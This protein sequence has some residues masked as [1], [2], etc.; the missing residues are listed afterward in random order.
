MVRNIPCLLTS[1]EHNSGTDRCAEVLN[2]SEGDYSHVVNIQ[3]DEPMLD[4]ESLDRAI[5]SFTSDSLAQIGSLYHELNI[6]GSEDP[7]KV[8]VVM[9]K[10]GKALYF[11]RAR[12]PHIRDEGVEA[13]YFQHIGVYMYR[14]DVLKEIS[15]LEPTALE[16]AESLEQLRWLE[17]GYGIR[18]YEGRAGIGI[19]TPEDLEVF[20][21]LVT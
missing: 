8:K 12:I 1:V 21:R 10:M 5:R 6:Q 18:M 14:G 13:E 2:R 20:R 15:A 7:S 3:G 9:D 19:D 4:H 11:S 17:H 16:R